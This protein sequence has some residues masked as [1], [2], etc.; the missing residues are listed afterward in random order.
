MMLIT[1]LI[2]VL[3]YFKSRGD[4]KYNA[5]NSMLLKR[6]LKYPHHSTLSSSHSCRRLNYAKILLTIILCISW[7]RLAGPL[8]HERGPQKI[9]TM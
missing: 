5:G 3:I 7:L 2:S 4:E 8:R 9:K 1:S 6:P